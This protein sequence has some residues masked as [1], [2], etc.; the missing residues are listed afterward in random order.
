MVVEMEDLEKTQAMG[1]GWALNLEAAG[2]EDIRALGQEQ[3]AAMGRLSSHLL[4]MTRVHPH[5]VHRLP[6]L[7]LHLAR[8]PLIL[9]LQVVVLPHHLPVVNQYNPARLLG[10]FVY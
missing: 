7:H 6:T 8:Y 3:L 2:V 1:Q 4:W 9:L 5:Q 10:P